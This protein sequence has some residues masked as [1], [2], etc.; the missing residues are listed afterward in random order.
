MSDNMSDLS[1]SQL[2]A[3]IADAEKALKDK[4][5]IKKKEVLAQMKAL[6]ASIDVSFEIKEGK[7]SLRKG[8]KVPPKYRHPN[9]P[10]KEWTGRGMQPGW[11]RGLIGEGYSLE[12]IAIESL[13]RGWG[14]QDSSVT[15]RL[16]EE[17][18]GAEVRAP[19]VDPVKSGKFITTHPDI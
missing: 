6:A 18:A 12:Q 19:H 17:A 14:D 1:E 4:K 3:M 10:S 16:Q 9:D 5:D 11:V 15:F 7:K 8:L 2:Q 13:N